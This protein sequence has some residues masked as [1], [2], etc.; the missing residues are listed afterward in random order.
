MLSKSSGV[1]FMKLET[2]NTMV[3]ALK[4]IGKRWGVTER[5]AH[6]PESRHAVNEAGMVNLK[7]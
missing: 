5:E 3:S 2:K 1:D 4:D 7:K 6:P